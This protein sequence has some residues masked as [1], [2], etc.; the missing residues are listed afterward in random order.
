MALTRAE[1]TGETRPVRAA[2]S[3]SASIDRDVGEQL[4]AGGHRW[5]RQLQPVPPSALG[6]PDI[7]PSRSRNQA[8]A[9]RRVVVMSSDPEAA[10]WS[11]L[12]TRSR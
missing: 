7:R 10:R 9:Q 8:T 6:R 2:S 1:T 5:Q 11:C 3:T 4:V 12:A